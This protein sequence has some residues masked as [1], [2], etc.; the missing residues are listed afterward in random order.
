MLKQKN[1]KILTQTKI[2]TKTQQKHSKQH[3]PQNLLEVQ[4][5]V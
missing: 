2:P 4:N 1:K 3:K 5:I